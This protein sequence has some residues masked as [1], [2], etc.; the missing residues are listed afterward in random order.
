MPYMIQSICMCNYELESWRSMPYMIQSI[1][2]CNYELESW[3]SMP[4]M[5]Q[6]YLSVCVTMSYLG[7][8]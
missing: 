2:M 4:Y 1:C 6:I 5:I 8:L 7:D 3:R